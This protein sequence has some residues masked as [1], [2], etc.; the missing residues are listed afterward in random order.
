MPDRR[1]ALQSTPL[2]IT[3]GCVLWVL[4]ACRE[5]G[6]GL[7]IYSAWLKTVRSWGWM[8]TEQREQGRKS[9]V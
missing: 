9:I 4:A 7:T 5:V 8:P 3:K 2:C 6:V 1:P